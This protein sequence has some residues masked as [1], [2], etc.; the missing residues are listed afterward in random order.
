MGL[1]MSVIPST[2]VYRSLPD[3]I[4]VLCL[5][6]YVTMFIVLC[7]GESKAPPVLIRHTAPFTWRRARNTARHM[8]TVTV[9]AFSYTRN[10]A[11]KMLSTINQ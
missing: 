8:I 5:H 6:V 9:L 1:C 10:K 4:F 11:G 2:I 3:L 7:V